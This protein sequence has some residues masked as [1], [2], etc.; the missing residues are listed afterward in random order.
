MVVPLLV[1][2]TFVLYVVFAL[3]QHRHFRTAVY[4]LALFDQAV[5]HY[6]HFQAPTMPAKFHDGLGMNFLQLGDHFSPILALLAPAYWIYP[7]ATVLLVAQAFLIAVSG[8]PVWMFARR[9]LGLRAAYLVT[10]GYLLSWGLQAALAVDFHEVAF[11]VPLMAFAIERADAGRLKTA[12]VAALALLL[13]KEDMGLVVAAFGVA[14]ML[15]RHWRP[16]L[17]AFAGGVI[18]F[19]LITRWAM[20]TLSGHHYEYWTMSKVGSGIG[21]VVG[22]IVTHPIATAHLALSPSVKWHTLLWLFAPWAFLALFSPYVL[23]VLPVLG[24]RMLG[25]K[26]EYWT[27]G[28]QY[29]AILMPIVVLAS[30]DG[31]L[32]VRALMMRRRRTRA[33][34]RAVTWWPALTCLTAVGLCAYFPFS[35]LWAGTE[36]KTTHTLQAA[37]DAIQQVPPGVAVAA[38]DR[39]GA[40]LTDRDTVYLLDAN[41]P[42]V[43]WMVADVDRAGFPFH[44]DRFREISVVL[45]YM[46]QYGYRIVFNS[47]GYVVLRRSP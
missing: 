22:H 40:H 14:L 15:K 45:R 11:G 9:R 39:L 32:R 10:I 27:T 46:Q 38:D 5:R 17:A 35:Y 30:V 25:V 23:P 24:E 34:Q 44:H 26:P 43:E 19:E 13:V 31:L 47:H 41:P 8:V 6:A 36:W 37:Y 33:A 28:H 1:V 20:P 21:G 18:G 29:N 4:D 16:G 42:P 12:V 3:Q 7:H 2:A